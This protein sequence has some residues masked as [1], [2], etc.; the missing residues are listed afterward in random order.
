MKDLVRGIFSALV[1][2]NIARLA[3]GYRSEGDVE[4]FTMVE[5]AL[6]IGLIISFVAV[7]Y[8]WVKDMRET[9]RQL[10]EYEGCPRA[11]KMTQMLEGMAEGLE[12]EA[13]ERLYNEL[14]FTFYPTPEHVDPAGGPEDFM[15]TFKKVAPE[16]F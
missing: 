2:R 15:E 10:R 9:K 14:K 6:W 16:L 5:V 3:N 8:Y 13:Q 12:R 4:L 11:V 7:A 1:E